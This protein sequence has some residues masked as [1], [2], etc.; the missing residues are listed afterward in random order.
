[1]EAKELASK[2]W[3]KVSAICKEIDVTPI[4]LTAMIRSGEIPDL[5]CR[6][7]GK[8]WFVHR[9]RFMAWFEGRTIKE[10]RRRGGNRR[11]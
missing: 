8:L 11:G 6:K 3:V 9:D 4:H 1:M 2:T 5:C 7:L 10:E